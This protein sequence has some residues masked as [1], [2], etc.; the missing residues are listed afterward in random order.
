LG[1]AGEG[2]AALADAVPV[3]LRLVADRVRDS[4]P[5]GRVARSLCLDPLLKGRPFGISP[6]DDGRIN[7]GLVLGEGVEEAGPLRRQE[8]FVAVPGVE[9]GVERFDV[10][11]H[12]RRCVR[13]VDN[14]H[15]SER[16]GAGDDLLH[17][18][19]KRG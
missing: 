6:A 18:Q 14:R 17:G 7:S 16:A 13:A 4:E 5:R 9:V 3:A 10:E 12:M 8:P 15:E 11:G 2:A 1:L 19:D